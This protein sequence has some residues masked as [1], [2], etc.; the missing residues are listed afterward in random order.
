MNTKNENN[1][2]LSKFLVIVN[3]KLPFE[4]H[5]QIKLSNFE[6]FQNLVCSKPFELV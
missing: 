4:Q 2:V 3:E 6:H 1:F 5:T